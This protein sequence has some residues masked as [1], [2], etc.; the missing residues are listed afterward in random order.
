MLRTALSLIRERGYAAEHGQSAPGVACAAAA[1]PYRIP[2]GNAVSCS[3]PAGR[4]TEA[5]MRR[6]GALLREI[7]DELGRRLRRA[8]IR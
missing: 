2:A 7:A 4:A 5:E 8:G 1:V 6:V 3:V